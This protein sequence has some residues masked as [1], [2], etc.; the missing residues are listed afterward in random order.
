MKQPGL[1]KL[2]MLAVFSVFIAG[3]FVFAEE[4]DWD[5]AQKLYRKRQDCF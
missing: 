1:G 5:K 3:V 2:V 4:I